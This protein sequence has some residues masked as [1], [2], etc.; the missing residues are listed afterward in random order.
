MCGF[1][2]K[3]FGV[4]DR[5]IALSE[6]K[7]SHRGPDSRGEVSLGQLDVIFR[8][9][10]IN[11]LANGEQPF[12]DS[13]RGLVTMVNGE[14]Y[15]YADLRGSLERLGHTFQTQSD[16]EVVHWGFAE[17]GVGVFSKLEGMFGVAVYEKSDERLTLARDRLGKKPLYWLRRDGAVHFSSEVGALPVSETAVS[18]DFVL[19]YLMTDSVSFARA[20][21]DGIWTVPSGSWIQF[22][23]HDHRVAKFWHL[24]QSVSK[25]RSKRLS[26]RGWYQG[27]LDLA[28]ESVQ[29]RLMSDVPVGVFLSNG[30]DSQLIAALAA[31][32]GSLSTAYTLKFDA[33]TFD[34][35]DEAA[36]F[37]RNLNLNHETVKADLDSLFDVWN[38]YR[39]TVDEPVADP[40]FLGEMLLSR[41]AASKTKVVLTG[42]GGDEIMLGYQHVR[43]HGLAKIPGLLP[44]IAVLAKVARPFSET[45]S[46]RYFSLPFILERFLRG[47]GE[48]DLVSRDLAWRGSFSH[49]RAS[50]LVR[51]A[52]SL[53][54]SAVLEFVKKTVPPTST[55]P[56]WQDRWSFLYLRSYLENVI[57]KK[58]D[59]ASMRFG[60][61]AR[62]P[63]LDRRVVEYSLSMPPKYRS[64]FFRQKMPIAFCLQQVLGARAPHSAKHGMGIPLVSL[65]QGPLASEVL[66]LPDRDFLEYQGIFNQK[67]VAQLVRAF[68]NEPHGH[69]REIWSLLVFQAWWRNRQARSATFSEGVPN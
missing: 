12:V 9:L 39:D 51:E 66:R 33:A 48:G 68:A 15:N 23:P 38:L 30:K 61:E 14:I 41:A 11:G 18:V 49:H 57:L 26:R 17:W 6:E 46:D 50:G 44:S 32:A 45:Q 22:G 59:R 5:G 10:A 24:E 13:E 60:V 58:V 31:E 1:V 69:V 42:D 27:F 67:A 40:A 29:Q 43:V 37:S 47:S 20:N 28:R 4:A 65:F 25:G 8:R 16:S 52:D 36:R 53:N 3:C 7:L 35:S 62:S 56:D 54:V 34:E 19:E 2:G 55:F 64:D 21:A 63:L